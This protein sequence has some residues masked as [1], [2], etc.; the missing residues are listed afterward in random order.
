[1][2]KIV[3][4]RKA[5]IAYGVA[6]AIFLFALFLIASRADFAVGCILTGL[7]FAIALRVA[8][9]NGHLD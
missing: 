4:N 1:M 6:S 2:R 7:G 5:G 8:A 9:I 3:I